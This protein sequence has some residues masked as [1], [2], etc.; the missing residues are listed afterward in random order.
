MKSSRHHYLPEFYIKGFTNSKGLVFVYDKEKDEITGQK[1]PKSIFFEWDRNTVIR[2]SVKDSIIEDKLYGLTDS[3]CSPAFKYYTEQEN[4]TGIHNI[5]YLG[6][7]KIFAVNL[8][9]RLPANDQIFEDHW[10]SVKD[11]L[12]EEYQMLEIIPDELTRK[13]LYRS[14]LDSRSLSIAS[15][16]GNKDFHDKLFDFQGPKLILTD[17][18]VIYRKTPHTFEQVVYSDMAFAISSN[19]LF[20]E[21]DQS[22]VLTDNAVAYCYNAIAIEQAE[23]YVCSCDESVLNESVEIYKKAKSRQTFPMLREWL[24]KSTYTPIIE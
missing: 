16:A 5:D 2:G 18:P 4:V 22:G 24:F 9:W 14:N 11:K 1:P 23:K 7:L 12:S 21:M 3:T 20:F 13:K 10:S 6:K 19:R 17:N 8:Y 15:K